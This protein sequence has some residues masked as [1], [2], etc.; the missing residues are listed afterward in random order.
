MDDLQTVSFIDLL[1]RCVQRCVVDWK[2]FCYRQSNDGSYVYNHARTGIIQ[3]TRAQREIFLKLYVLYQFSLHMP[4]LEKVIN[5]THAFE[6]Y[7]EK[8]GREMSL[9]IR[10]VQST[11]L[12]TPPPNTALAVDLLSTGTYTRMPTMLAQLAHAAKTNTVPL[13]PLSDEDADLTIERIYSEYRYMFNSAKCKDRGVKMECRNGQCILS[14]DGMFNIALIYDF[15]VWQA[16]VA[17][18]LVLDRLGCST[19]GDIR[20]TFLVLIMYAVNI[21]NHEKRGNVFDSVFHCA[22]VFASK[23][24][25]ERLRTQA[26]DYRALRLTVID[27]RMYVS[28][29]PEHNLITC[30][31]VSLS[32]GELLTLEVHSFPGFKDGSIT[33]LTLKF[34]M[35]HLGDITFEVIELPLLTESCIIEHRLDQWLD[36]VAA[37]LEQYQLDKL[38]V[39]GNFFMNYATGALNIAGLSIPFSLQESHVLTKVLQVREVL[40]ECTKRIGMTP[41]QDV[42]IEALRQC[43]LWEPCQKCYTDNDSLIPTQAEPGD[44]SYNIEISEDPV[45]LSDKLKEATCDFW[46]YLCERPGAVHGAVGYKLE[47]SSELDNPDTGLLLTIGTHD[48]H[49]IG[50]KLLVTYG[51][52]ALGVLPLTA[53]YQQY[54]STRKFLLTFLKFATQLADVSG[55]QAQPISPGDTQ[56]NAMFESCEVIFNSNQ[57]CV[58]R[59]EGSRSEFTS[60][61]EAADALRSMLT[62]I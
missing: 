62:G 7:L 11:D 43:W 59:Y 27:Y 40:M 35:D 60:H 16:L 15:C 19:D 30:T 46:V 23:L 5:A 25:M 10:K 51:T 45:S 24:V 3:F 1:A 52:S 56:I 34:S 13:P 4:K 32:E 36:R 31:E 37:L 33:G 2:L 41:G 42:P 58:I 17:V 47:Q 54:T 12:V 26:G 14:H 18:P 21:Y 48:E 39:D 29:D 22:N 53:E 55:F 38:G 50:N 9:N 49:I 61:K 44:T 28:T 57:T 6:G 8:C 20:N